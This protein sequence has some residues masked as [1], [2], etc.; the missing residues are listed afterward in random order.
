MLLARASD[1]KRAPS[2]RV[3]AL[4]VLAAKAWD[5]SYKLTTSKSEKKPSDI[6]K[7]K[8]CV[9]EGLGYSDQA[10]TLDPDNASIWSYK[11]NLLKE[12]ATLAGLESRASDKSSYEKQYDEAQ[13][14]TAE[15]NK[16]APVVTETQSSSSSDDR[17]ILTKGEDVSK[18]LIEFK[19]E[20]PL[21][22]VV[23]ELLPVEVELT[24]LFGAESSPS[25]TPPSKSALAQQKHDWKTVTAA[26]DL[27]VDL[28]DNAVTNEAGYEAGSEGVGYMVL[29][30]NRTASQVDPRV[31]DGTI[32]TLARTYVELAI[33]RWLSNGPGKT[34]SVK[35]LRK[36]V[37]HNEP[38]KVYA[39]TLG[40]CTENLEGILVVQASQEHLYTFDILGANETD[41]RT[42]RLIRS[43]KV[44]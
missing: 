35:F 5:C 38:R 31:L 7:A 21:D 16:K 41:A 25:P 15:A 19:A 18:D 11:T 9:T 24:S 32:N 42:Q 40:S 2:E 22:R 6:S 44:K 36:E 14:R 27:S 17:F 39:Y 1:S 4:T 43:I 37:V 10:L 8:A 12:A 13:K 33:G 26:E 30:T 3:E 34:F 29:S 28:P 20:M 23:S